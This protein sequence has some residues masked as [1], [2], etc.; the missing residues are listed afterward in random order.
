MEQTGSGQDA[1]RVAW[2]SLPG[3][4]LAVD[5]SGR[6]VRCTTGFLLH[7]GLRRN[8][9]GFEFATFVASQDRRVWKAIL[10]GD[11]A[12]ENG[13]R[14]LRMVRSD[15]TM[16]WVELVWRRH[17]DGVSL[18]LEDVTDL[19][20][21]EERL[22]QR[23]RRAAVGRLAESVLRE[24]SRQVGRAL[25]AIEEPGSGQE[26]PIDPRELLRRAQRQIRAFQ[27]SSRQ[28][29]PPSA[30]GLDLGAVLR[31][32]RPMFHA[33][34]GERREFQSETV[35]GRWV[36]CDPSLLEHLLLHLALWG[37]ERTPLHG[38]LRL[39]VS[40]ENM[41]SPRA[42]P[43]GSWIEPGTWIVLHLV[44]QGPS[45]P[46]EALDAALDPLPSHGARGPLA[47]VQEAIHR[48]GGHVILSSVPGGGVEVR[49]FLPPL[50][51]AES[52]PAPPPDRP[53]GPAILVVDDRRD[54]LTTLVRILEIA[55][56]EVH[57]TTD[58]FESVRLARQTVF[59]LV[60]TDLDMPGMTG[61]QVVRELRE[62]N[63]GL[64]ALL[65]SGYGDPGDL[66]P[67]AD[68][69][70]KPIEADVLLRLVRQRLH[71]L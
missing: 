37:A 59:D 1:E 58:P 39:D 19:H 35:Q 28:G 65:V 18:V 56:Y 10:D 30:E 26:A 27:E 53:I 50:P 67:R 45:L 64:P 32:V 31:S 52:A 51:V 36:R 48:C 29:A 69:L 15:G 22:R 17:A 60:V 13:R 9:S 70:H 6:I 40:D 55:G 8:P 44:D 49:L 43:D 42:L 54:V 47:P 71:A 68:F 2:D 3:A 62:D 20:R 38:V 57:G 33:A 21:L 34:L 11:V 7:L 66:P 12:D 63:P 46:E 23:D 61:Y 25:Q 24:I 4:Q 5:A 14:S 16:P 41:D